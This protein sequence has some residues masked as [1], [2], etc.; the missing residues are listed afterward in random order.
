MSRRYAMSLSLALFFL[1]RMAFGELQLRDQELATKLT[2]GYAVRLI[3]MNDDQRLDIAI[4]D[5]KRFLWL[6]NPNWNEHVLLDTPD[7][8]NDNVWTTFVSLHMT[9]MAM[10]NST[11]QSARIGNPIT[12]NLAA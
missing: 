2:V 9:S 12:R 6:E 1:T 5:S 7:Q 10:E 11:L 8:K 3:D 4:V